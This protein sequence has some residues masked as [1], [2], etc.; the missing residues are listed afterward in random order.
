MSAKHRVGSR[1]VATSRPSGSPRRSGRREYWS[2]APDHGRPPRPARPAGE[3][4]VNDFL[5]AVGLVVV[6]FTGASVLFT[7][8][9]P[10][11]P[12]G[13]ERLSSWS[14]GWSGWSSSRFPDWPG[15][16]RAR[17]P[18]SPRRRRSPSSPS[19]SSGP[20]CFIVGFAL[21]LEGTT[22]DFASALPS[23][24]A[25]SSRSASSTS[26][27]PPTGHRHRGRRHLGGHRRPADRL[28]AGP[29]SAPST[30]GRAWSPCWRAGPASR[31]GGPRCWPATS[32]SASST[33]CPTST[34]P[35]RSGRPTWPRAT[36]P[37]R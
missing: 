23:P 24:P 16:T 31:P 33:P 1:R 17:T 22:H 4:P 2:D 5:F 12:R 29:L 27:G 25:P 35:G 18:S 36:P 9:L 30:G 26:V 20:P 3:R 37:T 13:F 34:P 15:P 28:P 6:L 10:R 32:S 11:E 8:V 19:W 14:T 7:I 21:M